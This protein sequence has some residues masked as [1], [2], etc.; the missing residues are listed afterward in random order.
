MTDSNTSFNRRHF[1]KTAGSAS[2]VATVFGVPALLRGKDLNSKLQFAGIGANGKGWSDIKEMATH[3]QLAPVAFTDIDLTRMDK[4][5]RLA[6]DARLYQDYRKMLEDM[7][8]KIDA[9]TV[10]TPDHMHAYIALDLMRRGKHVYCQKPLTR[11]VWEARQVRNQAAKDKNIITRMGNQIHSHSAYL[12]GVQLIQSGVIGK[13]KEVHSWASPTGHGYSGL[14]ERPKNPPEVPTSINWDLW[15]GV[16]PMRP[17]GGERIY[18]PFAWRDWQD[19]GSGAIGDFGCHILDPVFTALK[20][21]GG[22][23]SIKAE[24]SG[25]NDEVWPSQETLYYNFPSTEYIAGDNI[26]ITWYDGGRQPKASLALLPKGKTL[27]RLG[28]IFVGEKGSMLLPHVGMPELNFIDAKIEHKIEKVESLNHYHGW[29]D[30]CLSGKQP[31]DGFEYGG[32]LTET[33]QLGNVAVHFPGEELKWDAKNLKITNKEEAN[34]YLTR[35]YR[36][37]WEITEVN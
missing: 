6:P 19:F 32:N 3:P 7:G 30:G 21:T 14:L 2:A 1:L 31:S 12:T 4:V 34:P 18:H 23:N 33:V 22:P 16:A 8:D 13:I 28:S 5:K 35:K 9:L 29:I 27:P 11:T 10:S 20:I 15:I 17:Y 36:K 26:N 25:I 37:G 24:H